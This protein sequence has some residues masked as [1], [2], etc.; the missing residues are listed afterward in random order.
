M[1]FFILG[2]AIIP[3]FHRAKLLGWFLLLSLTGI[4]LGVTAFLIT[5]YQLYSYY[6]YSKPYTRAPAYFVGVAA[7]WVLQTMEERGITRESQIF[8]R[9]Q[10]LATTAETWPRIPCNIFGRH[11]ATLSSMKG[12]SKASLEKKGSR[13]KQHIQRSS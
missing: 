11:F 2:I 1:I 7:A 4:S 6:A 5:K 10:S 3:I 8:G 12:G 13:S 9:K